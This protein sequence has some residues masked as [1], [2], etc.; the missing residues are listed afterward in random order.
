VDAPA[1]TLAIPYH[2]GRAYLEEAVASVL[3]QSDPAW[4]LLVVDDSGVESDLAAWLTGLGDARVRHL[5][6][7]RNLGMVPCWNRC[8]DEAGDDLVT[9]LHADDLLGEDY[10]ARVRGLAAEHPG[11]VA[12]FT[13]ARVIGADG[14]PR[15]SFQDDVKRF[16]VPRE[17]TPD[18]ALVLRGERSLSAVMRGNFLMCPTLCW[19]RS[20]LGERRFDPTW[21]QAQDL[22]FTARLLLAGDTLVGTDAAAYRY[23][24]H[25]GNATA[26]Q[27]ES[28]LRFEEEFAVFD[29][30]AAG[31]LER[32]WT[33]V[34]RVARARRILRLHLSWRV[35]VETLRLHWGVAARTL[36][37]L[38]AR[39]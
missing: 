4:H 15:R 8:I 26:R 7:P 6:N 10:V 16:F 36:R 30:V 24:R 32:G 13:G 33:S 5:A 38:L 11:A 2:S 25:A 17:R 23:R 27:T 39:R 14:R 21:K 29:R 22:E 1:V 19:R 37:F 31:A 3:R 34:V 28:L 9:L 20:V 35:L 18:G 12:L